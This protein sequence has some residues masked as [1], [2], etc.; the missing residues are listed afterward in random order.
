MV[1]LDQ[2]SWFSRDLG[3]KY[4]TDSS[5]YYMDI[6]TVDLESSLEDL[7][8]QTFPN[9]CGELSIQ[10]DLENLHWCSERQNSRTVHFL[11]GVSY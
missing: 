3:A 1:G 7:G 6:M 5:W 10:P 2:H 11:I 9:I 8:Q 4:H